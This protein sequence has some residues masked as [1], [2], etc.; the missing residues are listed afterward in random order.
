[1]AQTHLEGKSVTTSGEL[2]AVGSTKPDWMVT[3][4]DLKDVTQKDF[5]GKRK[6]LNIVPSLYTGVCAASARGLD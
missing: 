6:I 5:E 2:P 4:R 1:M 3:G